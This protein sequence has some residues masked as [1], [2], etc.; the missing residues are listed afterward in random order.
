MDLTFFPVIL[1]QIIKLKV[2]NKDKC[3]IFRRKIKNMIKPWLAM[4][5]PLY[6]ADS[7]S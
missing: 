1:N 7:Q 3:R 5:N 4:T 2:K 6:V